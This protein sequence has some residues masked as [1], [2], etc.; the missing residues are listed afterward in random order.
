L[1]DAGEHREAVFW[2]LA[3]YARCHAVLGVDAPELAGRLRPVFDA[4]LADLGM[5]GP[6]DLAAR[7]GAVAAAV[8]WLRETAALIVAGNPPR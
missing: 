1:I 7:A 6:A 5:V 3:S 2:M 8:P 4:A